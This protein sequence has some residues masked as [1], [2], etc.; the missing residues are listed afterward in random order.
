M[1]SRGAPSIRSETPQCMDS[2]YTPPRHPTSA[3]VYEMPQST[4]D[5][6]GFKGHPRARVVVHEVMYD[7]S[8]RRYVVFKIRVGDDTGEWTVARRYTLC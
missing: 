7:A 8:N 6:S 5:C 4:E 3:N 2:D 1:C